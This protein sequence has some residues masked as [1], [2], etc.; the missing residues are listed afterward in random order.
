MEKSDQTRNSI[1]CKEQGVVGGIKAGSGTTAQK[2]VLT[3]MRPWSWNFWKLPVLVTSSEV[4]P[5]QQNPYIHDNYREQYSF[6]QCLIS[7]FH[8]HNETMNIWSHI[9]GIV[10]TIIAALHMAESPD[11]FLPQDSQNT[12]AT[13][14]KN[15]LYNDQWLVYAYCIGSCSTLFVSV[16]YH[17]FCCIS[18]NMHDCLLQWDIAGIGVSIACNMLQLVYYVA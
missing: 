12:D 6:V 8:F 11:L 5:A 7:I 18:R 14:V 17:T 16:N 15:D 9:I 10:V 2:T 4:H 13:V 3:S 1:G